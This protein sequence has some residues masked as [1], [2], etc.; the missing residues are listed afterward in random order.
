MYL[1]YITQP[2]L[3]DL[4]LAHLEHA[5]SVMSNGITSY[6]PELILHE[7]DGDDTKTTLCV[8]DGNIVK[9]GHYQ[10]MYVL[11]QQFAH[12]KKC[13]IALTLANDAWLAPAVDLTSPRVP[14]SEHPQRKEG[15]VVVGYS[16]TNLRSAGALCYGR[17]A[18]NHM[19]PEVIDLKK[20]DKISNQFL[21]HFMAGYAHAGI[22]HVFA[23]YN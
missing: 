22:Q 13:I 5:K 10:P 19:E 3:D 21:N 7:L 17:S 4:V 6:A 18:D 20:A 16:F 14:P 15:I 2:W 11:G 9:P 12:Q 8:L 23:K 1:S